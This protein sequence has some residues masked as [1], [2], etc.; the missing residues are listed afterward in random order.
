[1]VN[2]KS[3]ASDDAARVYCPSTTKTT[4]TNVC[5]EAFG[6][7]EAPGWLGTDVSKIPGIQGR[8]A[9]SRLRVT[10]IVDGKMRLS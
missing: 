6:I 10:T 5:F 2:A 9:K 1:M 7:I 4:K 3:R 8:T